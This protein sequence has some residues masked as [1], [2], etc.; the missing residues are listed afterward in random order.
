MGCEIRV[1][2]INTGNCDPLAST[3]A[4]GYGALSHYFSAP[5]CDSDDLGVSDISYIRLDSTG[6]RLNF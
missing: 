3:N 5:V 2:N 1:V 4:P 6:Y